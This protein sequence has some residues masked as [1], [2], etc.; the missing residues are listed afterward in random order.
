MT[1]PEL[2][3]FAKDAPNALVPLIVVGELCGYTGKNYKI[4]LQNYVYNKPR[5]EVIE[6]EGKRPSLYTT[7]KE[8]ME[9]I[10]AYIRIKG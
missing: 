10:P 8:A 3:R 5:I 6:L 9:F 1:L 7:A 2:T 4:F